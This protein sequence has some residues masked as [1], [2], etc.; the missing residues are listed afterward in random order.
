MALHGAERL[1][2]LGYV[3]GRAGKVS[4]SA[5]SRSA[6]IHEHVEGPCN[7]DPREPAT[8]HCMTSL[9]YRRTHTS[10]T[11]SEARCPANAM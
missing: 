10:R 9:H 7:P 11:V 4:Q 3:F 6:P 5:S 8:V 1:S 2:R